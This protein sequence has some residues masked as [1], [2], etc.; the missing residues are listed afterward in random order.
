MTTE[1]QE[2][3]AD[4]PE[5]PQPETIEVPQIPKASPEEKPKAPF[6]DPEF[7]ARMGREALEHGDLTPESYEALKA[8]GIPE[9]LAKQYVQGQIAQYQQTV[10]KIHTECGGKE[11]VDAALKWAANNL[12]QSTIDAINKQLADPN[13]EV[14]VTALRGLQA[15]AGTSGP[16]L[17]QGKTG[18]NVGVMPYESEA[19]M[20]ADIGSPQYAKDPAFRAQVKSR[21]DMAVRSGRISL[22]NIYDKG[23]ADV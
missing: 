16:S 7:M 12:P 13:P 9:T 1:T 17:V 14:V 5:V 4:T 3:S 8:A 10:S 11:A 21:L 6:E 23:P 18:G 15:R 19:Q 22:S 2:T 20:L